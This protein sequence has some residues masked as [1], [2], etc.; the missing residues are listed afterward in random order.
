MS[1]RVLVPAGDLS[2]INSRFLPIVK[3]VIGEGKLIGGSYVA[4][5]ENQL[6]D[7]VGTRHAISVASG[8]DALILAIQALDFPAKSEIAVLNCG[9]GYASLAVISCGHIPVFCDSTITDIQLDFT[10]LTRLEGIKAVI[11]THLYGQLTDIS[12]IL[13]WAKEKDIRVIEDC[14]QAFGA[15]RSEKVAG[16]FGDIGCFSFY[17]TKNLGGIGDGGAVVTNSDVLAKNIIRLK[18]YGWEQRYNIQFRNGRNSRLDAINAAVLSAK[19]MEIDSMN[20]RRREIY[21]SYLDADPNNALFPNQKLDSSN[22]VHL[23]VG[24]CSSPRELIEFFA[25]AGIEVG[26][27]YPIPDSMQPGLN[28]LS[29]KRTTPNANWICQSNVTFPVYPHLSQNQVDHVSKTICDWIKRG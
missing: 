3:D 10:D 1:A 11:V 24:L 19:I 26:Q 27:H 21:S 29:E 7:Y 28:F 4:R 12:Q 6:L 23:A 9:G 15:K 22:V 8:M 2:G 25:E 17:P 14:A 5:F 18:Q 16:S 13:E 20:S